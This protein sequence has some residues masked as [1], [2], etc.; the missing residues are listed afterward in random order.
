MT[1][2]KGWAHETKAA[3]KRIGIGVATAI[4]TSAVIYFLGFNRSKPKA[5]TAEVK[6]NTIRVWKDYVKL[7]N[8]LQPKH[9][10]VFA[11]TVRGALTM[12]ESR[13]QDSL[14]SEEFIQQISTLKDG[15]QIDKD[16]FI[17]LNDRIDYKRQEMSYARYYMSRFIVF[18]D[19]LMSAD[20][21]NYLIKEL[22]TQSNGRR[23]NAT[24]RLG[25]NI[26]E[27]AAML[28]KKYKYPFRLKDFFFYDLYLSI[29][30]SRQAEV[31]PKSAP[32]ELPQ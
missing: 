13:S 31:G 15:A 19:S 3:A 27:Q 4:V 20:Y 7:E 12:E 32:P 18:R 22:N 24:E 21:R 17:L 11:Q 8:L 23:A 29:K 16:L 25:R 26:E 6:K 10:T 28:E 30:A 1:Q 9:D 2:K 14:I 5:S